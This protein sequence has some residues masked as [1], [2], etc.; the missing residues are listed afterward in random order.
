MLSTSTVNMPSLSDFFKGGILEGIKNLIDF[1]I[2]FFATLAQYLKNFY[3]ILTEINGYVNDWSNAFT[4]NATGL[5]VLASVGAYRYLVG[6]AA[7][8]I[9]YIT[10]I[11]GC[12]FTIF[13]LVYILYCLF[14]KL[15]DKI[16]NKNK[17]TATGLLSL[18]EK[19]FS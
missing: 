12:L 17:K 16:A 6:E 5:P 9:T 11:C 1:I 13:K 2:G 18:L 15:Q 7:F 10:I 3:E 8:Y 4:G 14:E 19:F